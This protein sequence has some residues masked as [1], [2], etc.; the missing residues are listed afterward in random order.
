MHFLKREREALDALLPGLDEALAALPL[1]AME[2]PEN[3]AIPLFKARRGCGLFVPRELG[4]LG[5]SLL[6][7]VRVQRAIGSRAPSLAL[8]TTMHHF[9]VAAL[10]D[11]SRLRPQP[12]LEAMLLGQIAGQGLYLASA[13]AEGRTGASI[14]T[15]QLRVERCLDGLRVTGSKRPCTLSRSMDL[16]TASL[17]VPSRGGGPS[18]FAVAIIPAGSPGLERRPFWGSPVLAGAESDEVI[19]TDVVVPEM[20]VAYLGDPAGLD[21]IQLGGF[22]AFELLVSAAYLGIASGLAER[23]L[24]ERRGDPRDRADLGCELEGA[25]AALE[26]VAQAAAEEGETPHLVARA[27]FVRRAVQGAIER[28]SAHAT[29]ILGGLAFVGQPDVAY[30]LAAT[31]A[32]AFHPPSRATAL[33]ALD[34]YLSGE[35]LVLA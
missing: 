17:L 26:G 10:V 32:L 34:R 15:S 18:E 6:D 3:P 2:R 4:G 30:L 13:F 14:F 21:A 7:G 12:G 31:R 28:A 27:L 35:P 5:A 25:M 24:R 29:E 20:H 22:L 11:L 1:L 8:A 23:A 33:A 9:S 16:L 19:L